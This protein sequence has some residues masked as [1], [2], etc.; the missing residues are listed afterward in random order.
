MLKQVLV[1][2]FTVTA[3]SGCINTGSLSGDTYT[4]SQAKQVQTVNYGTVT[5]VTPVNIQAGGDENII[6]ALG[7]AVLGGLLGNTVGGGT[8]KTLATAAGAIA[9]GVAGQNVQGA[10]NKT[11]GV[12]LEIRLDNGRIIS[13]VQKGDP[14]SFRNGQRV[15][16]IGSGNNITVSPR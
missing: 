11:K 5:R 4:A 6:G 13:V 9:G 15:S 3:L 8:G 10:L 12:Q 16:I 1:G 7:G 2:I 14:N